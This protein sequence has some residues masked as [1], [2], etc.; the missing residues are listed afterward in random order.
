M[1][2]VV[3]LQESEWDVKLVV[4]KIPQ[5]VSGNNLVNFLANCLTMLK[6]NPLRFSAKRV[7]DSRSKIRM[8]CWPFIL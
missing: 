4:T 2:A 7:G 6:K 5:G 3:P 8:I 1:V